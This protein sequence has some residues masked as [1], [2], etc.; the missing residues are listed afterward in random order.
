MSHLALPPPLDCSRF[1][2]NRSRTHVTR[3]SDGTL[4]SSLPLVDQV[5]SAICGRGALCGSC[6]FFRVPA[7]LRTAPATDDC[8]GI[9][10][11]SMHMFGRPDRAT[12]P[13][14]FEQ[15]LPH[16]HDLAQR[17]IPSQRY[18]SSGSLT[19]SPNLDPSGSA[20]PS[21]FNFP[22]PSLSFS[23]PHH[24]LQVPLRNRSVVHHDTQS[25]RFWHCSSSSACSRR[26][27]SFCSHS[28]AFLTGLPA[29]SLA[30]RRLYLVAAL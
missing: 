22:L 6:Q 19:S 3:L 18:P 29:G 15:Q 27:T 2:V 8:I 10:L 28:V 14:S 13:P 16:S 17:T 20:C 1:L 7:A 12:P 25:K 11:L 24:L 21:C 30:N 9:A 5:P 23:S 4:N 26:G